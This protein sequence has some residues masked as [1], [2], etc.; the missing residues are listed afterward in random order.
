MHF[1]YRRGFFPVAVGFIR[2]VPVL[3]SLLSLPGIS[4]VSNLFLKMMTFAV[5]FAEPTF[6]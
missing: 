3:G 5:F 1:L 2:R 6:P 4:A